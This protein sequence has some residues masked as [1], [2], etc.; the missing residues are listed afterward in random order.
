LPASANI[1]PGLEIGTVTVYVSLSRDRKAGN[2]LK[3]A[4][5]KLQLLH[6]SPPLRP[7]GRIF[8]AKAE[9]P[10]RIPGRRPRQQVKAPMCTPPVHT[11]IHRGIRSPA[12]R[13]RRSRCNGFRKSFL[14]GIRAGL[15]L[16]P[17]FGPADRS[18]D[19]YRRSRRGFRISLFVPWHA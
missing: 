1:S 17:P 18:R 16:F 2:F 9:A 3:K 5:A 11:G 15:L 14:S 8:L 13:K 6:F 7:T 12:G 19:G 4:S 10:V